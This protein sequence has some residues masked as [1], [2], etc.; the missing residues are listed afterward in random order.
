VVFE[1]SPSGIGWNETVLHGFSLGDG[2]YPLGS[3]IFDRDGNLWGTTSGGGTGGCIY[4]GCGVVFRLTPGGGGWE[5]LAAY[6]FDGS[7]G[8][9][10][11]A[12]LHESAGHFYGTT[13][14]G[15]D[16]SDGTI[17]EIVP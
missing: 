4:P 3:P 11:Y 1:L 16:S 14:I 9:N 17:F 7:S 12:G 6:N 15:G 5:Y 10:P 2:A 13:D 8:S